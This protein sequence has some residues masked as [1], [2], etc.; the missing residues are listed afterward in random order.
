MTKK[1]FRIV[2]LA[3]VVL[4]LVW[5]FLPTQRVNSNQAQNLDEFMKRILTEAAIPGLAV[6]R[7]ED[8][9]V[10]FLGSYGFADVDAGRRVTNET[11]F[12][13]ASISKPIL[14]V[15]LLQLVDRGLLDLDRDINDY[16]PFRVDN[17]HID[18]EVIT[19][20]HL[21][22]HSSGIDDYYDVRSYSVNRDPDV[23]LEQHIRSLLTKEGS[24]YEKGRRYLPYL[25]G[26]QRKYSNLSAG[27]AGLLVEAVTGTSLSEYSDKTLFHRLNLNN[28]SWRIKGLRLE[29]IA[30][31]Y[32]VKQCV[33]FTGFCADTESPKTN[34]LISKL[35]SPPFG[36][37]TYLAYPH[38]GNPQYPDGGIRTSIEDLSAMMSGILTNVDAVGKQLLTER[39]YGELFS[40]QLPAV[41]SDSQRFFWRD[42]N[43]QTG[44][45]GSDLG[46]YTST[47]FSLETRNGYI[48]LMNR[49]VDTVAEE[50]MQRIVMRLQ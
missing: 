43:G 26:T 31:P 9:E 29:T 45:T 42:R 11:L 32:E 33:P 40:L 21:A 5:L 19:V 17:P 8:G 41:I 18:G 44:H 7:L 48:V 14:G 37:K 22:T 16:L 25:P 23:S 1:L 35:F 2:T 34:L 13:I 47:Y 12:N 38:F 10:K 20:R 50:A 28:T 4:L 15:V 6:A 46:V 49:G 27:V 24:L 36:D 39:S 3:C 30:I